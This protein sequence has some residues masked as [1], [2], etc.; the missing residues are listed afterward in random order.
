MSILDRV[1][2]NIGYVRYSNGSS[3][4]KIDNGSTNFLGT[5]NNLELINNNSVLSGVIQVRMDA[6]SKVKFAVQVGDNRDFNHPLLDIIKKPNTHQSKEDFLK[7][8]ELYRLGYGWV[9]QRPYGAEGFGLSAIYNLDPNR[10]KFPKDLGDT[11]IWKKRDVKKYHKQQFAYEDQETTTSMAFEDVIPFYDIS[12]NIG[13]GKYSAVTSPSRIQSVIKEV[14]NIGLANDAENKIIQTNG[15]EML[16]KSANGDFSG[17]L[18]LS[19]TDK[20][21][22]MNQINNGYGLTGSRSRTIIPSVPMDWVD[23]T[24][25]LSDLGFKESKQTNANVIA[26]AFGV[27]NE[28]YKAFTTGDTFENQRQA[29]LNFLQNTMKPVADDLA[30]SWTNSFGNPETP[31]VA[32]Y[33]HLPTMQLVEESK[34]DRALKVSATLVNLQRT[35]L[36]IEQSQDY[37]TNLGIVG[38]GS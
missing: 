24:I 18:S 31:F 37:L 28:V 15:R 33:D 9:Y 21:N 8:Y 4:Y 3:F 16:I 25:K 22:V 32:S 29:E 10:I 20:K 1:L 19:E 30:S 27:P 7:Q 38:N 23:M 6:L 36:T 34:V 26:Q 35:G 13:S 2:S 5:G 11:I 14:S 17:A 12:N